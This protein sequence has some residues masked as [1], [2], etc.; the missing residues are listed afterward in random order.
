MNVH[1][2]Q[3]IVNAMKNEVN[4]QHLL[5]FISCLDHGL[6]MHYFNK[7]S[8]SENSLT[9]AL[10]AL[11]KDSILMA[12][13]NNMLT[14][15]HVTHM[16]NELARDLLFLFVKKFTKRRCVT[17]LAVDGFGPS[18][19]Q[20]NSAI[21]QLL[22]KYDILAEKKETV[23]DL[24][25]K[26]KSKCHG[27]GELGHWVRDCP[28]GYNKAWLTTQQCFKC[29]QLG[30]FRRDCRFQMIRQKSKSP[31]FCSI[32]QTTKPEKKMWYHPTTALPKMIGTLHSYDLQTNDKYVPLS[33]DNSNP[34]TT[35][36]QS[37]EWFNFRKGKINGSKAAVSLGWL[38]KP[39]M[40]D[41]W[42]QLRQG[43]VTTN[44]KTSSKNN[45]AMKWGSMC[46]NSA[47][48]TYLSKFLSKT[49]LI[50]RLVKLEFI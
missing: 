49:I 32:K 31:S 28:K 44:S 24:T 42:S 48:T 8:W 6:R 10:V 35:K 47:M 37:D 50:A 18:A 46:E 7:E 14:K 16:D 12:L 33:V 23:T 36:Q 3:I 19:H 4:S 11:K 22:K 30:H 29:G 27:C 1:A 2:N 43:E 25:D 40:E 15:M 21:R 45:L 39:V 34:K 9:K 5:D 41:Y 13:W 26:S 38:G 17:Y 20:D